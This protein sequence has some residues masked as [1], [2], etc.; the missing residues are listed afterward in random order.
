MSESE[1][2]NVRLTDYKCRKDRLKM[3]ERR[4]KMTESQTK[5]FRL[6]DYKC[7]K[8][9]LKLSERQI[10]NVRKTDCK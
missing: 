3:L 7:Q 6:T 4:T 8:D 2:K 9:G 5:N 1:T 10:K